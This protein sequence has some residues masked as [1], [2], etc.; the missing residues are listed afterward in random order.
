[1]KGKKSPKKPVTQ[2][3]LRLGATVFCSALK[4]AAINTGH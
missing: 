4:T 1:M 3:A 2:V